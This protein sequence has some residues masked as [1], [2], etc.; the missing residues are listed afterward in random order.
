MNKF[1]V[2]S[3]FL[4]SGKTTTLIALTKFYTEK[5]GKAAMISND[6]G[7]GVNLADN[8]LA[9]LEG[10]NASEITEDCICYK[11]EELAERLN[12]CFADG[13]DLVL[14]DIPGFGVGALEHVY[15]GLSEKYPGK[16]EL[17]PFT[18]LVEPDTIEKLKSSQDDDL[19]FILSMQLQEADLIVLNKCDTI[20]PHQID[21]YSVWLKD[22]YPSASILPISAVTGAGLEELSVAMKEKT[23]SMRRIAIDYSNRRFVA[24]MASLSEYYIQFHTSVCCNTF[25]G[26]AYLLDIA[27]QMQQ[28]LQVSGTDVPHLKLL[29][30]GPDG[31]YGKVDLIGVNRPAVQT[32]RFENPCTDLAVIMN[33]SAICPG[34]LFQKLMQDTMEIVSEK[35]LLEN[36]VF[37]EECLGMGG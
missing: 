15:H 22:H 12:A 29:A 32:K 3:G 30:W 17:A 16:Y 34:R 27:T 19:E 28:K 14:S 11:H 18:V 23:A 1:G 10:C 8:R 4:G 33:A 21:D 35:Y 24:S 37:K 5:Y 25:D 6:L 7:H 13:C 31:D 9:K 20:E 36:I 26:N 2:F